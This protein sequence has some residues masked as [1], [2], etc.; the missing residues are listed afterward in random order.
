MRSP[1]G[2]APTEPAS[3][4]PSEPLQAGA[5][6]EA[7][8]EAT[9]AIAAKGRE[10]GFVTSEDVLEGLPEMQLPP[11]QIEEFLAHVEQVLLHR[12][13]AFVLATALSLLV[14]PGTTAFATDVCDL[15][16]GI[17][18]GAV[19]F[20]G[21][22]YQWRALDYGG[23]G[24]IK[25]T[26]R[27][28]N[29]LCQPQGITG[30][31]TNVF[32]TSSG[33]DWVEIGYRE[34]CFPLCNG[35]RFGWFV[36]IGVGYQPTY[37]HSGAWDS[38]PCTFPGVG[39]FIGF[40]ATQIIGTFNWNFK[41]DC[42]DGSGDHTVDANLPASFSRGIVNSETWRKG[43]ASTGMSDDH[44]SLQYRYGGYTTWT[45]WTGGLCLQD[46][47]RSGTDNWN[48]YMYTAS[49]YKTQKAADSCP[50]P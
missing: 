48:G 20:D 32:R 41:I 28:V 13:I 23:Y 19:Y 36:E 5:L 26:D 25:I 49:R 10:R 7:R 2:I 29:D 9:E 44:Q 47:A 35:H 4:A 43:G 17:F 37:Y 38:W 18:W 8:S 11:E 30:S 39:N 22:Q 31:T 40:R 34:G 12:R 15:E 6:D 3:D 27:D 33:S 14:L 24:Q 46:F 45:L 42:L 16:D 1:A 21:S 50:Q